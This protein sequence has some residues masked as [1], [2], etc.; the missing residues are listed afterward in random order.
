[1]PGDLLRE[2]SLD[3]RIN[4]QPATE[5]AKTARKMSFQ[6]RNKPAAAKNLIS[7]PPIASFF[8]KNLKEKKRRR[9]KQSIPMAVRILSSGDTERALFPKRTRIRP[10]SA[11]IIFRESGIIMCSESIKKTQIRTERKIIAVKVNKVFP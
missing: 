11:M 7:P 2:E 9:P 3:A 8:A 1:M 10:R 4:T 6:P 5:A